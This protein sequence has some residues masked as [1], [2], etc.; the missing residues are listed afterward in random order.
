MINPLES[1]VAT[2]ACGIVLTVALYL[3]VRFAIGT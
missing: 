3:I 2:V 1:L